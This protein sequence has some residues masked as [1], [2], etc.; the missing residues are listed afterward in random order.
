MILK[1][2]GLADYFPVLAHNQSMNKVQRTGSFYF[3]FRGLFFPVFFPFS[4]PKN[5]GTPTPPTLWK[6]FFDSPIACI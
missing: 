4:S 3:P 5:P 6:S 1:P 2:K